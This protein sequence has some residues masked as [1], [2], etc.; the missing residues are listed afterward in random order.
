MNS[1]SE[2]FQSQGIQ[3]EKI[4]IGTETGAFRLFRLYIKDIEDSRG[5]EYGGDGNGI[6]E[7][8]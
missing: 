8:I 4:K 3:R 1:L 2:L 6:Y 7:N 5:V